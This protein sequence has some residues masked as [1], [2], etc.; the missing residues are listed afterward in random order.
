MDY[1]WKN[2]IRIFLVLIIIISISL[3]LSKLQMQD[4]Q[5]I[6]IGVITLLIWAFSLVG[7]LNTGIIVSSSNTALQSLGELSNQYGIAIL[8]TGV[9]VYFILRRIFR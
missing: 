2:F 7:W 3:Y 4:S 8:T 6:I 9:A 5:E 1:G